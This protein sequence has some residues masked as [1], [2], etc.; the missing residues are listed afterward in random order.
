MMLPIAALAAPRRGY[1]AGGEADDRLDA[2]DRVVPALVV[3]DGH[4][5]F[6]SDD[7]GVKALE[8]WQK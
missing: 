8:R 2:A 7:A 3:R 1:C 4:V 6:A 5:I